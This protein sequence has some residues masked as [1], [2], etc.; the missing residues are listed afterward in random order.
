MSKL[1]INENQYNK[2]SKMLIS[3]GDYTLIL[4]DIRNNLDRNYKKV[5]AVVKNTIDY[6]N[7]AMIEVVVDGSLITPKQLLNYL[8]EKYGDF[9]GEPFLK[10]V[11]SDWFNNSFNDGLLSKNIKIK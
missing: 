7:K 4:N 6:N 1:V 10:Q 8:I 11:I 2:L 9:C 5:S 3:E